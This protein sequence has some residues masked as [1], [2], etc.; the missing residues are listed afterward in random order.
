VD[1]S[2]TLTL[3][4]FPSGEAL[5]TIQL[6]AFGTF[7]HG[8]PGFTAPVMVFA[9]DGAT[10]LVRSTTDIFVKSSTVWRIDVGSGDAASWRVPVQGLVEAVLPGPDGVVFVTL[11]N[12]QANA[13]TVWTFGA[14]APLISLDGA[15]GYCL[16]SADARV[17]VAGHERWAFVLD[18]PAL[19]AA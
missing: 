17:W 5:R 7:S 15:W 3:W 18:W 16:A 9:D 19:R 11:G 13:W 10:L 12:A 1:G 6:A 2:A 14:D 4:A 8:F